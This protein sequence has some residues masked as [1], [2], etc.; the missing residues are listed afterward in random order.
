MG[1]NNSG[2]LNEVYSPPPDMALHIQQSAGS[3]GKSKPALNY[4]LGRHLK[5]SSVV[6]IIEKAVL[7]TE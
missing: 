6:R 4:D 3:A 5:K 2:R 1:E 7:K